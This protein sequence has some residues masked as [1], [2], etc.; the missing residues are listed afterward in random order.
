MGC[1][2]VISATPQLSSSGRKHALPSWLVPLPS[3]WS[4][5]AVVCSPGPWRQGRALGEEANA[6]EGARGPGWAWATTATAACLHLQLLSQRE[7]IAPM[8]PGSGFPSDPDRKWSAC[9]AGDPGST[10]G[11]Q[12]S[13]GGGNGN[14][15][16]H[17]YLEK[18]MDRGAWQA[19]V[20]GVT[21]SRTQLSD[22]HFH[23]QARIM[24]G[25]CFSS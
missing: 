2:W 23:F 14:R 25:L 24:L 3:D 11:S 7:R 5:A 1:G 16:L 12:R 19:I 4:R 18:S 15:L 13:P 9:N 17:S 8:K 10:P 6:T 20:H 21:K 22:L